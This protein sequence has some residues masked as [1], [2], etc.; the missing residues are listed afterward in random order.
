M[1]TGEDK[2]AL[3]SMLVRCLSGEKEITKIIVF[4]S[5][6]TSDDPHD[7]DVVVFQDS[8]E[9]YLPL[10]LKYRRRTRPVSRRLPI[11]IIPLSN[12]A[13]SA[14]FLAEIA[15]GEVLYER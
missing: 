1:M 5:F 3:K 12:R 11:D 14:P 9:G 2:R 13:S 10:A 15:R 6:L 7:I 4:G 8:A